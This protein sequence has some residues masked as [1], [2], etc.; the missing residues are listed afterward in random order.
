MCAVQVDRRPTTGV[1]VVRVGEKKSQTPG[2]AVPEI[3]NPLDSHHFTKLV[4]REV[5]IMMTR[6]SPFVPHKAGRSFL[7]GLRHAPLGFGGDGDY[8]VAPSARGG[9]TV[10]IRAPHVLQ[11]TLYRTSCDLSLLWGVW[12]GTGKEAHAKTTKR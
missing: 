2:G 8:S 4:L 7:S 1:A 12:V 3:V 10:R 5:G 11:G 9:Q 6:V